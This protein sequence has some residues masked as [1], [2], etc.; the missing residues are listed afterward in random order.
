VTAVLVIAGII[1]VAGA[2]K[3]AAAVVTH[4]HHSAHV[5]A[6]AVTS[7][8]ERAFIRAVLADLGAPVNSAN[9][10]S[11]AG[12][13]T[14]EFPAWPPYA[15]ENPMS[16]TQRMP[17]STTYNS[18]GVQNYPTASEGAHAT[19]ITL[20]NGYYP[21]VVAALRSGRGLCGN[22]SIAGELLTW[23]GNGYSEVC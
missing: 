21:R 12:W 10:A 11:L 13:F 15:A 5:T 1:A 4:H 8:S 20:A 2:G 7:G 19:A 16:S 3:G 14:R 22:P 6:A 18:V 23:S 9:T 17:G